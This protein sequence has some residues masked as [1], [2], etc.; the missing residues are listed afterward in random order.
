MQGAEEP[1]TPESDSKAPQNP[2]QSLR[3]HYV[4]PSLVGAQKTVAGNPGLLSFSVAQFLRCH[5]AL[6][7][8]GVVGSLVFGGF[9][10]Y[11]SK[12]PLIALGG[13]IVGLGFGWQSVYGKYSKKFRGGN[14]CAAIVVS[15]SPYRIAVL[16]DLANGGSGPKLAIGVCR[17]ELARM[18]PAPPAKGARLVAVCQ[19]MG[20]VGSGAWVDVMPTVI[21]CGCTN[22]QQI[23]RAAATIDPRDYELLDQ[24]VPKFQTDR[25]GLHKLWEMPELANVPIKAG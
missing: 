11:E 2:P 24:L 9:A 7:A 19:Y 20:Q 21:N 10:F 12:S 8:Y 3:P 14:L 18:Y 23:E 1:A 22:Q 15:T 4:D 17:Q 25:N 5:P 16:T 6:L 13:V